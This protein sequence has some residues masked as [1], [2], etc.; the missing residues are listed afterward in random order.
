MPIYYFEVLM[1]T[2]F[3]DLGICNV[4]TLVSDIQSYRNYCSYYYYLRLC[5]L[6]KQLTKD[7]HQE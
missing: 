3:S 1:H 5:I 2:F 4:L 7:L 6:S